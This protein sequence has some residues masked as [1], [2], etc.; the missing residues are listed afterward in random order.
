[1]PFNNQ[2]HLISV[3]LNSPA[4]RVLCDH[5]PAKPT[6]KSSILEVNSEAS[7]N[8]KSLSPNSALANNTTEKAGGCNPNGCQ[9]SEMT[10]S[11]ITKL[12]NVGLLRTF[13]DGDMVLTKIRH[14]RPIDYP[15]ALIGLLI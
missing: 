6:L 10:G 7:P 15:N 1:M 5:Y 3:D 9:G 12:A 8:F 2:E 4:N 11:H 14:D 13:S